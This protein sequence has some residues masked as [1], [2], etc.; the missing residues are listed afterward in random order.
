MKG[1][2]RLKLHSTRSAALRAPERLARVHIPVPSSEEEQERETE[3]E[4]KRRK[5]RGNTD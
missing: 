2:V 4:R 3:I 1:Q 5:R